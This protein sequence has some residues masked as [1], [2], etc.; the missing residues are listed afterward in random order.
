ETYDNQTVLVAET[1]LS[2]PIPEVGQAKSYANLLKQGK[3]PHKAIPTQPLFVSSIG[4]LISGYFLYSAFAID[5]RLMKDLDAQTILLSEAQ[6]KQQDANLR[7][8][9][10]YGGLALSIGYGSQAFLSRRGF[11]FGYQSQW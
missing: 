1:Q 4:T 5:R 6:A 11:H 7:Y 9:I 10:G 3:R 2:V 8:A